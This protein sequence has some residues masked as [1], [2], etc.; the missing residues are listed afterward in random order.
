MRR[1][2]RGLIFGAVAVALA[3]AAVSRADVV[4]PGKTA[5]ELAQ[6]AWINSQPLT[7]A[8]LKGRVVL[9]DFWT[10]G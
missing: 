3:V 2:W 8:A 4:A 5:P 10:F 7:M 6:G 1:G 9:V